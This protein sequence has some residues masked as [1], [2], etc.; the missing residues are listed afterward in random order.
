M[1]TATATKSRRLNRADWIET[2][3]GALAEEGAAG[4]RVEALA[5]RLQ[6]TKG[7]FY[8]HFKD[9]G[10]LVQAVLDH[11]RDG[12]IEAITRH[13]NPGGR[14]A[15]QVLAQLLDQYAT[16]RVR[17]GQAIELAIRDW[18]RRDRVV[19]KVVAEVDDYRLQQVANLFRL[20][21][22]EEDDA[23]ARAYLFYAYIFGQSLLVP[24]P[25]SAS[26]AAAQSACVRD[27]IKLP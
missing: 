12:R 10:D 7:G 8:W 3:M 4:L 5:K 22:C 20:G 27:L 11:W 23:F 15:Q 17:K 21:G 14:T 6:V 26:H 25:G 9:R 18:A 16:S 19:E 1:A 13:A 2:A 24:V